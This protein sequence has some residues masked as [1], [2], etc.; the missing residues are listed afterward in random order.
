M[1]ISHWCQANEWLLGQRDFCSKVCR[2]ANSTFGPLNNGYFVE[3]LSLEIGNHESQYS[4][5]G[6]VEGKYPVALKISNRLDREFRCYEKIN[7]MRNRTCE[8]YGI[9]F[10][11]YC[12]EFL[13]LKM[14]AMTLLEKDLDSL[15]KELG[16]FSRDTILIVARDLVV[17][18]IWIL[19]LFKLF[20]SFN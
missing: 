12:G 15:R 11:Y 6:E 9:T 13:H 2:S 5:S 20:H 18:S 1:A 4:I 17:K 8:S 3:T 16:P 7:A 14:L 10:I 19:F